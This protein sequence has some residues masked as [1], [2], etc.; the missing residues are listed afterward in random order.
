MD[1]LANYLNYLRTEEAESYV[2]LGLFAASS[3]SNAAPRFVRISAACET[4]SITY[5]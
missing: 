2:G 5:C 4:V 1:S 3:R